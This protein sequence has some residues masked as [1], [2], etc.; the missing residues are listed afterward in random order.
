MSTSRSP[1]VWLTALLGRLGVC[2][3]AGVAVGVIT[4]FVLT[5]LDLINGPLGSDFGELA[6]MWLM[7]AVFGWLLI[8]F[9]FTVFARW[10]AASVAAPALVNSVLVTGLTVLVC[11]V[12]GVFSLAWL[13]GA[14]V[15]VL[16][17]YLLCSLYRRATRG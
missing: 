17:G 12:A 9:L 16:V 13:V 4:G 2:G 15:G 11:R 3:Q 1:L 7:L 6:A 5:L 10:S 14:L 8:V